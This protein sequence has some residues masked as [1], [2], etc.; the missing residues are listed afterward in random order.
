[1][2]KLMVFPYHPDADI[3]L[4][5]KDYLQGYQLIGFSSFREDVELVNEMNTHLPA[6]NLTYK[7]ILERSDAVLILDDYRGFKHERYYQVINDALMHKKEVIVTP[8]ASKQL[9]LSS[10]ECKYR[11]LEHL[12]AETK[13]LNSEYQLRMQTNLYEI[14]QPIIGV[15]GAGKHCGKFE[16]QL[17]VNGVL[18]EGY[19][20][21]VVASNPLGALFGC[22]TLPAFMH[23]NCSFYEKVIKF[24]CYIRSIATKE[25]PDIITIGIP[26]GITAFERSE[27]NHFAEYPLVVGTAVQV[28]TAVFCTY[29]LQEYTPE[30]LA[31]RLMSFAK[32]CEAKFDIPVDLYSIS[33]TVVEVPDE[34]YA[35]I[36]YE[37]VDA[38]LAPKISI[39]SK[40]VSCIIGSN[41]ACDAST[42]IR[43]AVSRL[44]NN[45]ALA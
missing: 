1:M 14:E 12:P 8:L 10:C 32:Y 39:D 30:L 19:R 13:D 25:S 45:A 33:K 20:M 22:Y 24:N 35:K 9:D 4:R 21:A 15:L 26:E 11:M 36:V 37:F 31:E 3:L 28:D 2:I 34:D 6:S 41:V 17:L 44:Q 43:Q 7:K 16:T 27:H 29:F 23:E 42:V 18:G 38:K 5:Y 40:M